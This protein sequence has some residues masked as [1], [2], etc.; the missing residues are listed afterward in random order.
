M[1][2]YEDFRKTME[3]IFD[4]IKKDQ[5]SKILIKEAKYIENIDDEFDRYSTIWKFLED[6]FDINSF[7]EKL[8]QFICE[9]LGST[10]KDY[11]NG[12]ECIES[13]FNE[14]ITDYLCIHCYGIENE[15]FKLNIMD[16]LI[17][18]TR[19][20][21]RLYIS[22]FESFYNNKP[23]IAYKFFKDVFTICG[24]I[25]ADVKQTGYV[26]VRYLSFDML[27]DYIDKMDEND[28]DIGAAANWIADLTLKQYSEELFNTLR[29]R[30]WY[31]EDYNKYY[32]TL[33]DTQV[34]NV[35]I[36]FFNSKD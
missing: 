31:N 8:G 29:V 13:I 17:Y 6:N 23:T 5:Q 26:P 10:F 32:I 11:K 20:D 2:T 18:F 4:F 1:K 30:M 35:R 16:G 7:R 34:K 3:A 9:Y 21:E 14:L 28:Y 27:L 19:N 36:V 22:E 15:E 25:V 24:Q 33:F 12:E